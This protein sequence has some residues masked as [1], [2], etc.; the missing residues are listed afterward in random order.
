MAV[1]N[2]SVSFKN[3]E[4]NLEEGTITEFAKED[5]KV[6]RLLDELRKFEGEG[7]RI[8]LTIKEVFDLEPAEVEGE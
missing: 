2:H 5:I 4:I 3:A 6:Y 8:N 1:R 7:R